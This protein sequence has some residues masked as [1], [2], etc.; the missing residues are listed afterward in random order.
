MKRITH[1][2]IL[3]AVALSMSAQGVAALDQVKADPRKAYGTDYPYSFSPVKLTKAPSGYKA[4]YISHYGRHGSRYYWNDALYRE[5]DSLLTKAHNRQQLTAEGEAFRT[6]FMA[7]KDEL[8]VSVSELSDL[9]WEQHQR[10]AR[11]MYPQD[12]RRREAR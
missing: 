6:K 9:G 7:A 12:A 8:A 5:L 4:F 2:L 1:T 3:W 10:I 11:T